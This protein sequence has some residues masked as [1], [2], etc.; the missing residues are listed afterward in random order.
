MRTPSNRPANGNAIRVALMAPSLRNFGGQ[1]VQADLLRRGWESENEIELAFVATDPEFPR[2]VAW[3]R[4]V[5]WVRTVVRLPLYAKAAFLALRRADIAHVFCP[6]YVSFLLTVVPVFILVK[7]QGKRLIVHY[8][9]GEAADDLRLSR[10]ARWMLRR[11]ET[12]I[13]PSMYLQDI[14]SRHGIE[15]IVVPN[16]I[17]TSRFRFRQRQSFLPILIC[18]RSLEPHYRVD[19]VVRAFAEVRKERPEAQLLLAG[20]GSQEQA[21]RQLA[22]ELS[23]TGVS[24]LG[25][26]APGEINKLYDQADILVNASEVDNMPVSIMEAFAAGT[27]VVSSA[28]GGIPYLV[29]HQHTGLLSEPGDWRGLAANIIRV[30]RDVGLGIRLAENAQQQSLEYEWS[31]VKAQWLAVYAATSA[32]GWERAIQSASEEIGDQKVADLICF[33]NDWTG[34]PLSKKHI[35]T[36]FARRHRILWINSI[37]N[38]RPRLAQKD[39]KRMWQKLREFRSGLR[40]VEE[41]IW[42]LTPLFIPFHSHRLI[43]AL[44]RR[45]LGYQIR[46]AVR[47]LGFREIVSWVFIPASSDVVGKL[48]EKRIVYH[49]VDEYGAFSDAASEIEARE[50]E[51]LTKADLVIVSSSKLQESKRTHNANTQLVLHGVD[52]EHFSRAVESTIAIPEELRQLPRPILGFHGL[53]ADWVDL[54]LIAVVA[55]LQRTGSVEFVGRSDT[56]LTPL[57]H[58]INVY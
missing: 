35:M 24:F 32:S 47:R 11:A 41:N 39:A 53:I 58:L 20:S 30:C 16:V 36:R 21:I 15:T 42:V 12:V 40:Q 54:A 49:C 7:L 9:S 33:A 50:N 18:T 38:R 27:P 22:S 10:P 37:N 4:H 34:D 55:R 26:V 23:L 31:R 5:P 8:H 48:G 3:V 52:F 45:L 25:A 43:R 56:D 29:K 51:L 1:S 28:A 46:C 44:N 17:D 13:V 14:V 19:N 2:W 57:A 6:A